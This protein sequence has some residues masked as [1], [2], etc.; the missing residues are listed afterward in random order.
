MERN[1]FLQGKEMKLT[2]TKFPQ[3]LMILHLKEKKNNQGEK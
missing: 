2:K 3:K 1:F